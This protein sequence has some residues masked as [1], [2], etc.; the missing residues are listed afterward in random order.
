VPPVDLAQSFRVFRCEA[1]DC[2]VLIALRCDPGQRYCSVD[3]QSV[4]LFFDHLG[5]GAGF[6]V[7]SRNGDVTAAA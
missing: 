1:R 3:G 7:V 6:D 5:R 2:G 4:P